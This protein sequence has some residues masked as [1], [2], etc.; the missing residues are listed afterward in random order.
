MSRTDS[1][2]TPR[3]TPSQQTSD[4]G[5][6]G[7]LLA[8]LPVMEKRFR[9]AGISTTVLEGGDGPP[10]VLLHGPGEHALKWLRVVPELVKTYRVIAP[11]LPGHGTSEPITGTIDVD[12]VLAWLGEL[13]DQTCATPPIVVGQIIGGAIAARF[14]AAHGDRLRCL[15]LSDALGLSS[16]RPA[17]EFGA[18]LMAFVTESSAE[19][20]DLLWQ[21]C[22]FD[23]DTLCDRMG[24]SWERL[25]AYNLDRAQ[26]AG[27]KPTQQSMME[28]F[29]LPAIPPEELARIRVPTVLIWGRHDLATPLSVAEAAGVLYG[30]PLHVIDHAADDPPI[31]QPATFVEALRAALSAAESAAFQTQ[32]DTRV[33]WNQIA[34]GYDRTNTETQ[35]WLA[36]EG[37]RRAGLRPGMRFIDIASGSGALSIPA[38]R[39]GAQVVAIDQSPAML[40]LLRARAGR[41]GLEIDTRVMDGHALAFDDDGFDIAGSQFGVMLF[42]DMPKGVREMTRVVKPGGR[43]LII[44][45]GNPHQIDFLAFLVGA[46]QSV[47]PEFDG[48]HMNPPPLPFQLSDPE[49][50][51]RELTKVGL[52]D[53]TVETITEST[54]F[55]SGAELWDWIVWSNPIVEEVLGT[56]ELSEGERTVI[57]QRLDRMVRDRAGDGGSAVLANPVNIG[58]GTK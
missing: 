13:V 31:E 40:R 4:G 22:A 26:V 18:A 7:L 52:Q 37:L 28:Q 8:G 34:P 21:R 30:W 54:A 12:R 11:D 32:S 16:F 44:A 38:A 9:F 5:P 49:R 51:A 58:T 41:D 29:G 14:A 36:N 15:V 43:V 3:D 42:P 48:P 25:R 23:L 53:V 55:K 24:E 46:V 2:A 19:N 47:R 1:A 45:Y 39:I 50:L 20:H 56:L 27:L 10:I 33:A 17:P 57:R 35:M 6:R